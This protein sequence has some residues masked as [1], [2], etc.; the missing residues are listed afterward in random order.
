[1]CLQICTQDDGHTVY[2]EGGAAS[3]AIEVD[4]GCGNGDGEDVDGGA[5]A[6]VAIFGDE[7][8][9]ALDGCGFTVT[10]IPHILDSVVLTGLSYDAGLLGLH[11]FWLMRKHSLELELI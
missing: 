6:P 5:S 8:A 3:G 4:G 10:G 2:S 9:V 7:A 1:M 11:L